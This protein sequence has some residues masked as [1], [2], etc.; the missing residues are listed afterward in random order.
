MLSSDGLRGPG[1]VVTWADAM[2]GLVAGGR[3]GF[4]ERIGPPVR[5]EDYCAW[6]GVD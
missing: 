2:P 4:A 6:V 5:C 1:N 3:D